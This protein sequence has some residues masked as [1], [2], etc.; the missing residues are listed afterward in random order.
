MLDF[1]N[2]AAAFRKFIAE[3]QSRVFNA[4]LNRI[5]DMHDAEELTQDVFIAVYRKPNAFRGESAVSTWL[6]RIAMNK[7]IDHLRKKQKQSGKQEFNTQNEPVEFNHPGVAAENRENTRFLFK[8]M[9]QLPEKQYTAW[10]LSEM[11]NLGYKEISD[12]M[13][14]SLSSVESL[15]FRAR[16]NLRK[17]L[18]NTLP[19]ERKIGQTH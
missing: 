12:I 10:M 7:C 6:Y 8:A 14:V 3:H 18:Q 11:E 19:H 1:S 4:I 5:Q 13:E 2:D 17:Y 15:L 16:Q 9:Q